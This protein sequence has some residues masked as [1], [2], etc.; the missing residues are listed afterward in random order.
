MILDFSRP[1]K[2]RSGKKIVLLTTEY[3]DPRST[4]L[5]NLAEEDVWDNR[6][7]FCS[8]DGRLQATSERLETI[9]SRFVD[10]PYDLV[11]GD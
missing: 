10:S 6:T 3:K 7:I 9:G 2:T 1:I 8:K 5:Y 11:Y 4:I